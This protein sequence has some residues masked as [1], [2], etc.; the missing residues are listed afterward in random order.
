MLNR[1][2]VLN[3]NLKLKDFARRNRKNPTKDENKIWKEILCNSKTGYKF[4][5]QKPIGNFILDFYCSQLL[6]G[7]EV[8]GGA[9]YKKDQQKYDLARSDSLNDLGIK[10]IRYTNDEIID[11]IDCV[12]KNL[13]RKLKTRE[14]ESPLVKGGLGD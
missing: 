1:R 3:Y 9:H 5:R 8:D 6:L 4:L 11:N 12:Y 14:R 10:I 13:I 2:G 7:I